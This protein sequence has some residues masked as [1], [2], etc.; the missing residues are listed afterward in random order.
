VTFEHRDTPRQRAVDA[1]NRYYDALARQRDRHVQDPDA[2]QTLE[3][4]HAEEDEVERLRADYYAKWRA[5]YGTDGRILPD[6]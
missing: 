2:F 3:A 6:D 1:M 4:W 5:Q